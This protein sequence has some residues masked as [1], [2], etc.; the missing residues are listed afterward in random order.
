MHQAQASLLESSVAEASKNIFNTFS[1]KLGKSSFFFASPWLWE[2]ETWK[3]LLSEQVSFECKTEKSM[4]ESHLL[5][6]E[7]VISVLNTSAGLH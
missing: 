5:I 3:K 1:I 4:H 6:I 7:T 2:T